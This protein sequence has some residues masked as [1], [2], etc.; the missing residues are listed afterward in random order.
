MFIQTQPTPNPESLKFLPGRAVLEDKW[1]QT[2]IDFT[3]DSDATRSS[4]LARELLAIKGCNRV[5]FAREFISVTKEEGFE[6]DNIKPHVFAVIMD[7]FASGRP[8][9]SEGTAEP[10]VDPNAVLEDDD[11]VVALI[12]ELLEQRIRPAVQEDG[13]DILFH[14]FDTETGLVHLQLAGSCAGCPSSSVTL[15]SGVENMLM[16]Y[17]PEVEGVVSVDEAGEEQAAVLS[18][19][20]TTHA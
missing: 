10:P 9:I 4:A 1:G 7:F 18:F 2:S 14:T 15:K 20:P 19:T 8:V 13:G 6:W 11:E 16:H 5:F 12:K 17:I 3:P